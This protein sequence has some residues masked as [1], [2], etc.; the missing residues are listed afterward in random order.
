MPK[1]LVSEE[2]RRPVE[3]RAQ[4]ESAAATNYVGG[5]V[6]GPLRTV[7]KVTVRQVYK[8]TFGPAVAFDVVDHGH[9]CQSFTSGLSESEILVKADAGAA[10]SKDRLKPLAAKLGAT[11]EEI[12]GMT[13]EELLE[14]VSSRMPKDGDSV[15]VEREKEGRD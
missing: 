14:F 2:G 9:V 1:F 13:E 4:Y 6:K 11:R 5:A 12:E 15:T 10:E 8:K 7:R 3:V